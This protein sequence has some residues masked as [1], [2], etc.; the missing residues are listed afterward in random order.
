MDR[1]LTQLIQDM[2]AA[3]QAIAKNEGSAIR[4][5]TA[6]ISQ[7]SAFTQ[8]L[9]EYLDAHSF[10]DTSEEIAF[11]KTVRPQ[12]DGLLL[13]YVRLLHIESKCEGAAP[14]QKLYYYSQERKRISLF[15]QLNRDLYRYWLL[16]ST[17]LDHYYFVRSVSDELPLIEGDFPLFYDRRYYARMS[18]KVACMACNQMILQ[19]LQEQ[20]RTISVDKKGG[21]P[22]EE[23]LVW[24][25][26]ITAIAE[27]I[28]GLQ[29]YG[30][31]NNTKVEVKKIA[32]YF[33]ECF[34]VKIE[35][36]IHKYYQDLRIRKKG[37]TP[38]LDG[39]RNA[40]LRRMDEDDLNAL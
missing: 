21:A 25:A 35:N 5:I 39:V 34:G 40:L 6:N 37:R 28:Y 17:H 7:V 16:E 1:N 29:E 18:Y 24:T 14:D 27:L 10:K 30:V 8:Q 31:F 22:A 32:R 38:F 4:A 13:Y 19:Y 9:N 23:K 26:S 2:M 15:S 33:Q 11:F 36:T 12:F 3:T 20:G